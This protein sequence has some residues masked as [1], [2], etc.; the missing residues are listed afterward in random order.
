M[1]V[2]LGSAAVIV[3][4]AASACSGIFTKQEMFP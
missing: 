1:P 3:M 4:A 2:V